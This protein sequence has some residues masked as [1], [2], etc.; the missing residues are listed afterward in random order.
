M[1]A[2]GAWQS[3]VYSAQGEAAAARRAAEPPVGLGQVAPP[4]GRVRDGYG[5]SV[6]FEGTYL[7]DQQLLLP[8]EDQPNSYRVVTPLRQPDGSVVAV[9]R[10]VTDRAGSAAAPAPPVGQIGQ[11][12][13]LLPSEEAPAAAGTEL[14]AVRLPVLAQRWP[15][16]LIDGFVVLPAD[17]ARAQGL[18]PASA[19]LPEARGRLRNGAYA[20][21]WW[22][23][24][25]FTVA[26]AIKM[27]R[28]SGRRVGDSEAQE[29]E[30]DAASRADAT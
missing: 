24:A 26:M 5:R 27:A 1:V 13:V 2:M 25:A 4:V 14:A 30:I 12:G 17:Q 29:A 21:Q 28:D 7:P 8:M 11:T 18:E 20:L 15:G 10:G 19:K 9:V 23:F 6:H 16:P 22:V 3:E